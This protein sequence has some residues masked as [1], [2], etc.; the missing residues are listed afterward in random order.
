VEGRWRLTR[1]TAIQRDTEKK[2]QP[3][4]ETMI[5]E[6]NEGRIQ[7]GEHRAGDDPVLR[8]NWIW[9]SWKGRKQEG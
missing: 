7:S 9:D 2:K 4:D 8:S 1:E 5:W 3:M 6:R